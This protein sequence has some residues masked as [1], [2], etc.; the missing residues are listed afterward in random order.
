MSSFPITKGTHTI[1]WRYSK[2][3]SYDEG[4]DC[5]WVDMISFPP[6][7]IVSALSPVENLAAEVNASTVTLSWDALSGADEYI[8][9]REGEEVATQTE[10]TFT[11]TLAEGGIYVYS[12]IARN[13][14]KYSTPAFV[15]ANVNTVGLEEIENNNIDVYPNPTTGILYVRLDVN[16]DATVYNYQGQV[17]T[18]SLNNNG[19][20]D[21]S[22]LTSG[23]YFVQIKTDRNI[24][25]EKVIIR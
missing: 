16:F 14:N 19:Q 1:E 22:N 12:V 15:V 4:E 25:V 18:K 10:T 6:V 17:V 3:Y 13:G 8:V 23:V 2:D 21:L 11:E 5:A 9:R 20:I 24:M 7:S